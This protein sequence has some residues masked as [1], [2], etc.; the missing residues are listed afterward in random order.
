MHVRL[1]PVCFIAAV[2][3]LSAVIYPALAKPP[4]LPVVQKVD[5]EEECQEAQPSQETVAVPDCAS[6]PACAAKSTKKAKLITKVYAVADLVIPVGQ[7]VKG[8]ACTEA[9]PCC[10]AACPAPI[11]ATA[12][13]AKD[14]AKECTVCCPACASA[15]CCTKT[16]MTSKA[17]P[18]TEENRL[19]NLIV[20]NVQPESWAAK[21][22]KCTIQYFPMTMS[23][24]ISGT[25][26]V[27]EQVADML[28]TLRHEQDT[29]VAMEVRFISVSEG[30]MDKAG[31]KWEGD[32]KK[33]CEDKTTCQGSGTC[34]KAPPA[35]CADS[36]KVKFLNDAEMAKLLET[37]QGDVKTNLMQAPKLTTA[38]G[39]EA[40]IQVCD[41]QVFVT[42]VSIEQHDGNVMFCPRNEACKTGTEVTVQPVVS[43]D[44]RF[45][46]VKL[47]AALTSLDDPNVALIP[48][49]SFVPTADGKKV[50]FTQFIQS[51]KFTKL[52]VDKTLSLPDGGT[53]LIM[54]GKKPCQP[55]TAKEMPVLSKIPYMNKLFHTTACCE[56]TGNEVVLM[57]VTPRIIISEQEEVHT[58]AIC[59]ACPQ[60]KVTKAT[61]AAAD[62]EEQEI[63]PL[64]K[65]SCT[66]ACCTTAKVEVSK[67]AKLVKQYHKAC[68]EGD[69]AKASE[70]AV[71][72][73]AVDPLCFSK[74]A[75][76]SSKK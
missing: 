70:L 73:L 44:H 7:P 64:P 25:A 2:F 18:A 66:D 61:M 33:C 65:A 12:A 54:V 39:Q 10:Q 32:A 74:K 22:G 13:K 42:G 46:R 40:C 41:E 53:A 63:A 71:K 9:M 43:A 31:L 28:A 34:C 19:I 60:A 1:H 11:P 56:M 58:K 67:A 3:V 21:G 45:V 59:P 8:T 4:Q 5:F 52:K 51:P 20:N 57:M 48:V 29:Q 15:D 38:N 76:A 75:T 49:S 62:H 27:H 14:L 23:L 72:A 24:A 30:F 17:K 6:C 50:P 69:S 68:A 35:C 55:C 47:N 16:T 36:Q 26:D 37:M